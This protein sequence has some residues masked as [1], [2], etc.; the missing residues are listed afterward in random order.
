[1]NRLLIEAEQQRLGLQGPNRSVC[2]LRL[3]EIYGPGRGMVSL[4]QQAAGR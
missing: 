2:V 4:V 1:M 3:G